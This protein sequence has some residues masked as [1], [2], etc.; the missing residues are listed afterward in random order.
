MKFFNRSWCKLPWTKWVHF[1]DGDF[2]ALPDQAGVYRVRPI[3]RKELMYIGQAG[4]SQRTKTSLRERL[5]TLRRE[6]FH[7]Q[8]PFN[9]P[10]TAAPNL[11]AWRQSDH[12]EYECSA[13]PLPLF[14]KRD[15]LALE[16]YLLWQYRLEKGK[17]PRC[18][19][20]RFHP[21]YSK[22]KGQSTHV[23]G[24]KY[25]RG[26][27]NKA[28]GRSAPPLQS[29]G[30]PADSTWMGLIWIGDK[31]ESGQ[32][33]PK[34]GLYKILSSKGRLLYVG[35]SNGHLISR[36]RSHIRTKGLPRNVAIWVSAPKEL[37]AK[38]P[39]DHHFLE[40]E[41]DLIASYYA[42]YKTVPMKQ[43]FKEKQQKV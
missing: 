23:R 17:S 8:M 1:S 42:R 18:N 19:L 32:K 7:N 43:F 10:H 6:T 39:L 40:L 3:G 25:P 11:W 20:G 26:R 16:C 28:G 27:T 35:K 9:D 24:N 14:S 37:T 30:N 38:K 12:F 22:S 4:H 36:A 34:S 13:A 33:L 29:K 15:R 41:N 31:R 5:K 21:S 2:E